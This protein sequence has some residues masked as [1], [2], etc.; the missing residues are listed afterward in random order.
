MAFTGT[1]RRRLQIVALVAVVA[2]LVASGAWIVLRSPGR[3]L[4]AYFTSA[5]GLFPDNSVRVLGVPVGTITKVTPEGTRVRVDMDITDPDLKI[6]ADVK[7]AV[8]S[9]SLVTGN[10]VQLTPTYS[11][12]PQ[13]ADGGEIPVDRTAVPLGV[14]DLA[15][16]A[17]DLAKQLGPQGLNSQGALSD[18]LNVGAQ[19]LGGN[20]QAL[21]DTIRNLGDLSGTLAGSRQ[22]L[23]GT[24]TELQKFT[25]TIAANDGQ[26]REFN[27]RLADVSG[28]LA[29]ERQD[30]GSALSELSVALG[31]VASFVQDNRATLKSN[32]D[33]LTGITQTLVDQQKA[34]AEV[35]DIAPAAL[36]NLAN[37][38]NGSSGTLDTRANINELTMP[39]VVLI[40]E[41]IQRGAPQGLPP[42]L[43]DTCKGLEP[44]T[45]GAVKLPSAAQVITALQSGSPP[46]VPGLALPTEPAPSAPA[47]APGGNR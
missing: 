4:T 32:V 6:P 46:P 29:G 2:V 47:P 20:G 36:S 30:L 8:V 3:T 23:F 12:G 39:P 28:L 22:D 27:S 38:Y 7:A 24:I 1:D 42:G 9:P 19:N 40:C 44:I 5:S 11:G 31:D 35:F 16:T 21:N 13:M 45:S 33:K 25:S 26:V 17:S 34:L 18:A 37:A 15:R 14:D 10:Y 43:A 41:M